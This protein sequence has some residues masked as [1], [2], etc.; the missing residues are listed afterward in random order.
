M[1]TLDVVVLYPHIPHNEGL[2]SVREALNNR[3]N[4]EIPTDTIV[5]LAELVLRN[6]NFEFNENHYL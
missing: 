2:K 1:V 3:E 6:N 4:S 5:D